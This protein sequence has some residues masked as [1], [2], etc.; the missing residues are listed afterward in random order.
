M[1]PLVLCRG[2]GGAL[3]RP[4]SE[5]ELLMKKIG[6]K[7]LV[8][9]IKTCFQN[10]IDDYSVFLHSLLSDWKAVA[11]QVALKERPRPEWD[12]C[13]ILIL[14]IVC[15]IWIPAEGC[16]C[17][18]AGWQWVIDD[19]LQTL[20]LISSGNADDII[21]SFIFIFIITVKGWNISVLFW[22]YWLL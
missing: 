22:Q 9:W 13:F 12:L 1:M 5:F 21:V 7:I 14:S 17:C 4:A 20:H 15:Q 11:V 3:M 8:C 2:F 6:E 10:K 19:T 16:E 18:L